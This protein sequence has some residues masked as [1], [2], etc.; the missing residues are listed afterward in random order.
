MAK[1]RIKNN[2]GYSQE[3][4]LYFYKEDRRILIK[5]NSMYFLLFD[6]KAQKF[7][8]VF[9]KKADP[10]KEYTPRGRHEFITLAQWLALRPY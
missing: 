1:P 5:Y 7:H 4:L 2:L 6:Q 3:E 10:F 9:S 8:F